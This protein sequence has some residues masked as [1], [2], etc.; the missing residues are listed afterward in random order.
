MF[1]NPAMRQFLLFLLIGSINTA[2]GYAIYC[3]LIFLQLHYTVASLLAMSIGVLFNFKTTGRIVFKN[4]DNRLFLRF[5]SIY[6]VLYFINISLI[7]GS[8]YFIGS[9]YLSGGIAVVGTAVISFLLNKYV[10]FQSVFTRSV[11]S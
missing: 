8:S 11:I 1:I 6:V 9:F 7:K 2:F 4:K 5:V 10:V 3:L